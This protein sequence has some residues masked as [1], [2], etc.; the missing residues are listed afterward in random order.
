MSEQIAI[1]SIV[2]IGKARTLWEVVGR[3]KSLLHLV[4]VDG[5]GYVTYTKNPDEVTLQASPCQDV[6]LGE[7]MGAKAAAREAFRKVE[8]RLRLWPNPVE[9]VDLI[10]KA[11]AANDDWLTAYD[12]H[13]SGRRLRNIETAIAARKAEGRAA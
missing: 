5:D 8:D 9:V 13:Y 1:G 12:T 4:K 3:T 11:Q 7:L 2:T 10:L 6:T